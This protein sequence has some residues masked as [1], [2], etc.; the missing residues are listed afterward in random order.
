M[1][2]LFDYDNPIMGFISTACDLILL[3]LIFMVFCLPIITIGASVTSLY[4]VTL[5]IVRNEAPAIWSNFWM[6]FRENFKVSTLI[7]VVY[8]LFAG[9]LAFNY[10]ASP[11]LIPAF[12]V[13]TRT[14]V[15]ILAL[16][17]FCSGMYVFPILSRF[18][19]TGKQAIKNALLMACAHFPKT[20]LL[21]LI[22]CLCPLICLISNKLFL[23][24]SSLFLVCGF[25]VVALTASVVFNQIFRRYEVSYDL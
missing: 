21:V 23:S 6:S 17:F 3:N 19:C 18:V 14:A 4:Y 7:W 24:V 8:L 20:L 13:E 2:R 15:I 22:H 5:K 11:I 16:L 1:N 12:A 25:S 9:L 10:W